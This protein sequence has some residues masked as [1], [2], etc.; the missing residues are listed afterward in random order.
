MAASRS[1][2]QLSSP[3]CPSRGCCGG[4]SWWGGAP[5]P[6]LPPAPLPGRA[7]ASGLRS[8][9]SDSSMACIICTHGAGKLWWAGPS[10]RHPIS[11][12]QAAEDEH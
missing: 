7:P 10:D 6:V 2:E 3:W 1:S 5:A 8:S 11:M 4:G 12:C 9:S